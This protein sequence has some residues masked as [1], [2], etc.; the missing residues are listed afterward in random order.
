MGGCPE[1]AIAVEVNLTDMWRRLRKSFGLPLIEQ[2]KTEII[3]P[4]KSA[5]VITG[6]DMGEGESTSVIMIAGPKYGPSPIQASPK[7]LRAKWHLSTEMLGSQ[8]PHKTIE[9]ALRYRHVKSKRRTQN[10]IFDDLKFENALTKNLIDEIITDLDN[11]VINGSTTDDL[12]LDSIT[13][14]VNPPQTKYVVNPKFIYMGG[15]DILGRP[16][17]IGFKYPTIAEALRMRH[18]KETPG[19]ETFIQ[20]VF[21]KQDVKV[22]AFPRTKP[23]FF[24]I[25]KLWVK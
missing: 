9:E 15:G 25:D 3:L 4:I 2:P 23:T 20:P 11:L 24:S 13:G 21:T 1:D 22:Q 7:K 17:K 12:V 16:R 10:N 5:G 8:E 19:L 14:S 18:R 6:I